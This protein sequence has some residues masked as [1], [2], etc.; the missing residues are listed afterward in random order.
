MPA[1]AYEPTTA[2][3][4]C[5]ECGLTIPEGSC[6]LVGASTVALLERR[7]G[8]M[9]LRSVGLGCA[10]LAV[11]VV[12]LFMFVRAAVLVF[13][14]GTSF[15]AMLGA[16]QR[17]WQMADALSLLGSTVAVGSVLWVLFNRH[18]LSA[19]LD[20]DET[21]GGSDI[22]VL[23][24]PGAIRVFRGRSDAKPMEC[25]AADLRRISGSSA[26]RWFPRSGA[27]AIMTMQIH[28]PVQAS[29]AGAMGLVLGYFHVP[30]GQMPQD[31]AR[32]LVY[33][34]RR[35]AHAD[36]E[37]PP[38]ITAPTKS[39]PPLCPFC[40]K[41][42][43]SVPHA[44]G[45][46][47]EPLEDVV[48]CP[49][50]TFSAPAGSYVITGWGSPAALAAAQHRWL[51]G[52]IVGVVGSL[53]GAATLA[54][55][56]STQAPSLMLLLPIAGS[57]GVF[58]TLFVVRRLSRSSVE[59]RPEGRFQKG[60]VVWRVEPGQLTIVERALWGRTPRAQVTHIPSRG[61]TKLEFGTPEADGVD[62][63]NVDLLI[64]RGTAPEL[65]MMGE[66]HLV[67]MVHAGIDRDEF[68]RQLTRTLMRSPAS[69]PAARASQPG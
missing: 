7:E 15:G 19:S 22:R 3:L 41:S 65:G 21:L 12:A 4:N 69:A 43:S 63:W 20:P 40:M 66:R 31:I 10:V 36:A 64:A 24:E 53:V 60:N 44:T 23:V 35:Q 37:L 48:A 61:I 30:A 67:F 27:P 8:G 54:A 9:I 56:F 38:T 18:R 46:W 1:G 32:R 62:S 6:C 5:P 2:K 29:V 52:V 14:G 39:E 17:G 57:F 45:V 11:A 26:W 68:T 33:V 16:P 59:F 13:G 25:A 47:R 42:L 28:M 51:G 50:C 55:A 58:G 34:M 49:N